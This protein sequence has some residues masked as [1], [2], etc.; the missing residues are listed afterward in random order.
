MHCDATQTLRDSNKVISLLEPQFM[1]ACMLR[2]IPSL[3]LADITSGLWE[4][5]SLAKLESIA[6][7]L[8]EKHDFGDIFASALTAYYRCI[9]THGPVPSDVANAASDVTGAMNDA[10]RRAD[11][12]H[13]PAASAMA[14]AV[15]DAAG[16]VHVTNQDFGGVDNAGRHSRGLPTTYAP[17][18][19]DVANAASDSSG[20]MKYASELF[21]T[22]KGQFEDLD[23]VAPAACDLQPP[24]EPNSYSDGSVKHPDFLYFSNIICTY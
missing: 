12:A 19:S 7:E 18:T 13:F 3:A 1:P 21:A 14:N 11:V 4:G 2:G 17:E 24:E 16:A 20:V 6:I 9:S 22:L 10:P 15:S 5:Q 8:K 23:L